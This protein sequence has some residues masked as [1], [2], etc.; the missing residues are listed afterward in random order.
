MKRLTEMWGVFVY[1]KSIAKHLS[2]PLLL[3]SNINPSASGYFFLAFL[4]KLSRI[5]WYCVS[6][7]KYNSTT[8][9]SSYCDKGLQS[10]KIYTPS[11]C[12]T[13]AF[14]CFTSSLVASILNDKSMQHKTPNP[15]KKVFF[16]V[17]KFKEES[18]GSL[19][20]RTL[21]RT[22]ATLYL[23]QGRLFI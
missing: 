11:I 23:N 15:N 1:L 2:I 16:I 18:C 22:S 4:I 3:K 8:P 10:V 7:E 13:T 20:I 14:S 9:N 21:V 17:L 5:D 12:E 19:T 6:P